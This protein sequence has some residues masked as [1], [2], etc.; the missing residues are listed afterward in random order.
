M[1]IRRNVTGLVAVAGPVA[2]SLLAMG[3]PAQA[4]NPG[5][6]MKQG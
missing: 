6:S 2:G 1:R 5:P 3:A 4:Y